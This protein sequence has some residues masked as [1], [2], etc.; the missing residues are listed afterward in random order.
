MKKIIALIIVLIFM[1]S[2]S[3]DPY[4]EGL[5]DNST[6]HGDY[7]SCK[8][9]APSGFVQTNLS[10]RS[11]SFS[12]NPVKNATFYNVFRDGNLLARVDEPFFHNNTNIN[13]S[14]IHL[15]WITSLNECGESIN[16]TSFRACVLP[17]PPTNV[18]VSKQSGRRIEVSW[19]NNW[20]VF[21]YNVYRA[22]ESSQNP[23]SLIA[24]KIGGPG[25]GRQIFI[26][27]T[28]D[29]SKNYFYRITALISSN[30]G[31][32]VCESEMSN[33]AACILPSVPTGVEAEGISTTQIRISWNRVDGASSY[34]V[35][36]ATSET[37]I[38]V[39]THPTTSDTSLTMSFTTSVA[40]FYKVSAISCYES[41]KSEAVFATT[42][43][44]AP[45][46]VSATALSMSNIEISWDKDEAAVNYKIY[47][48]ENRD[49]TFEFIANTVETKFTDENLIIATTYH[50]K[51]SSVNSNGIESEL[52]SVVSART[53]S[54]S[55]APATPSGLSAE[56]L[57]ATSIRFSWTESHTASSYDIYISTS[58]DG[59]F[60]HIGNIR[61]DLF[62]VRGNLSPST[63]YF[64]KTV[65]INDCGKSEFSQI[66]SATTLPCP[67]E[68]P[69]PENV[70][71]EA[72]SASEIR[73]SWSAV[74]GANKYRI[75]R[76][77]SENGT[78]T[79][80]RTLTSTTFTDNTNLLASTTYF[81]KIV[82]VVD[83]NDIESK[84]SISASATT[85]S[86]PLPPPP[87]NIFITPT[88]PFNIRLSWNFAEN[89]RYDIYR[90]ESEDGT[91][92]RIANNI[93]REN[94][95]NRHEYDDNKDL[96][97]STTY[98][99]K[100]RARTNCGESEFSNI[101]S[102]A[103][104][105]CTN[106]LPLRQ[107]TATTFS[108]NTI[109]IILH[110]WST[111]ADSYNIYRARSPEGPYVLA[112]NL[113]SHARMFRD[114]NL[115]ANTTFFY[116]VSSVNRCGEALTPFYVSAT[117]ESR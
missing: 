51:V 17:N 13:P 93:V 38:Y 101:V 80:V 54:C 72:V 92:E 67:D 113:W 45:R 61:N 59:N 86:C 43:P 100:L 12:W 32:I 24:D 18:S 21:S 77:T 23:F 68:I 15:Y 49:G 53:L 63:K 55:A 7:V 69:A 60:P 78:Y 111:H 85:K 107:V 90:A 105:E 110:D 74:N 96:L 10:S 88:S 97:P 102:R 28:F 26:D 47:R 71:A 117:T 36:S 115:P 64:F 94:R 73:I 65:A 29:D 33:Y 99:Y 39:S 40:R 57:S 79:S 16:S 104:Q 87:S 91:F 66:I 34:R 1:F 30:D 81:Y 27:T 83:C 58:E 37:G 11:V 52:S 75:Y 106:P 95:N 112:G 114:N 108:S 44:V 5:G 46:N 103:T 89:T 14:A 8:P 4:G 6:G 48:S 50:Y 19:D 42:L 109:D 76:A 20:Q 82:A 25:S 22:E 3:L 31:S 116:K 2:C 35:Y 41:E 84:M 62:V 56:A 9:S 98:F 70:S